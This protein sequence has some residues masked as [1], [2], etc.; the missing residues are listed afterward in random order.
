M[1]HGIGEQPEAVALDSGV[2]GVCLAIEHHG[3]HAI[4]PRVV[5]EA[6]VDLLVHVAEGEA[7]WKEGDFSIELELDPLA[8]EPRLA[9]TVR[10][11]G[12]MEVR[13]PFVCA[14]QRLRTDVAQQ[15]RGLQDDRTQRHD[16]DKD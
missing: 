12:L 10:G 4:F 14:P 15:E 3:R 16:G 2:D 6:Q 8:V 1:A 11:L 9:P 5:A 7:R 13:P